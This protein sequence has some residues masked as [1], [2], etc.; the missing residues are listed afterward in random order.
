MLYTF[1][2]LNLCCQKTT[3]NVDD[4]FICIQNLLLYP[5]ALDLSTSEMKSVSSQLKNNKAEFNVCGFFTLKL[6]FL[7]ARV[8]VIFTY[9]LALNQL[10]QGV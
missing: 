3:E 8:S 9:I 6:Q 4:I 10:S 2:W 1:L 7:C 5:N